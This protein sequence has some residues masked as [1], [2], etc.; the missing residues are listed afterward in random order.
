MKVQFKKWKCIVKI[1]KYVDNNRP[2][3]TLI[4]EESGEPIAVASV[5]LHDVP[6]P[7]DGK[8]TFIKTWS[9]NEGILQALVD[10][11]IVEDLEIDIPTGFVCARF[12]KILI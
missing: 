6:I 5:N 10:A 7:E 11:K 9:E 4:G 3:I 2:A 1:S 12:V 8:H